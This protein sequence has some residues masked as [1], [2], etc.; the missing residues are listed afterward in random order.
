MTKKVT[1]K[2]VT[3]AA[4]VLIISTSLLTKHLYTLTRNDSW[5]PVLTGFVLSLPIYLMYGAL[6]GKFPAMTLAEIN[7]LVLGPVIGK[8]F[9]ALYIFFFF[10]IAG[11]NANVIAGFIKAIVLPSTPTPFILLVFIVVCLWAVRK[12]PANMMKYS[13]LLLFVGI[14][15]II[16]N[17]ILLYKLIDV[18]NLLPVLTL[19]P[20]FYLAGTHS[21]L[22]V[23][24][25]DPILLVMFIPDT[26]RP[27]EFGKALI[28]RRRCRRRSSAAD[29]P[30]RYHRSGGYCGGNDIPIL[31]CGQT[32][33]RGGYPH[34][35]G[36]CL[37][38][39]S[40]HADV[41]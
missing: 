35:D 13:F 1:S 38:F 33:Q 17:T 29:S 9:S 24:L 39:D 30:K 12:G 36:H 34:P 14:V 37:Y 2:Q 7:D 18:K 21:I 40:H 11:L 27:K 32:H 3:H 6:A 28:K 15:V 23:P 19:P 10:T 5:L 26:L 22:L 25:Y 16:L 8:V 41:F 20:Q 31:F 4:A